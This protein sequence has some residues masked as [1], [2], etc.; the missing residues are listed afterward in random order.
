MFSLACLLSDRARP[1]AQSRLYRIQEARLADAGWPGKYR[2]STGQLTP[3]I[4]D[5]LALGRGGEM[6][7]IAQLRIR[8]QLL[9]TS[10]LLVQVHLIQANPSWNA[11]PLCCHQQPVEH[12]GIERGILAGEDEDRLIGVGDDH[13]LLF[14]H[15]RPPREDPIPRLHLLD[16]SGSILEFPNPNVVAKGDQVCVL[17]FLFQ[18]PTELSGDIAFFRRHLKET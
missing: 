12:A 10:I 1:Q 5:A 6:D 16:D 4:I 14:P 15:R 13:L 2:D 18:P 7:R 11:L 8:L 3:Q 17:A 9:P